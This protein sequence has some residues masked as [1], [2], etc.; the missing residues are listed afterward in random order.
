MPDIISSLTPRQKK[1]IFTAIVVLII[2]SISLISGTESNTKNNQS[3][4]VGDIKQEVEIDISKPFKVIRIVDGDTFVVEGDITVRLIGVNTPET[5]DPRKEVQCFG[6]EA[7]EYT[8]RLLT[9]STVIFEIDKSQET[10]DRYGRLLAYVWK[11]STSS[12]DRIFVNK[13][14]IENGYAYEY[15]YSKPYLYQSDFREAQ[16]EARE[17]GRG[18]WSKDVCPTT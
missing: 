10:F 2:T 11:I 12:E 6:K 9:D 8:K 17:E 5:V 18:L 4:S 16:K 15:T 13:D 1:Q 3:A 7:S 14:L